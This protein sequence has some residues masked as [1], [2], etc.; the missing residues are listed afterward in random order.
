MKF[1]KISVFI[2]NENLNSKNIRNKQ[3]TVARGIRVDIDRLVY[4]HQ[5]FPFIIII[6]LGN[7]LFSIY[8]HRCIYDTSMYVTYDKCCCEK[9]LF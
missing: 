8:F 1:T 5:S 9:N 7:Y 2:N 4:Y 6:R 3:L